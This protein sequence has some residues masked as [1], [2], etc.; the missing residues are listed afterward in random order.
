MLFL[1]VIVHCLSVVFGLL[2][3]VP[4]D[5]GVQVVGSLLCK[6]LLQMFALL[7]GILINWHTASVGFVALLP[8][9]G[10]QSV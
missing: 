2:G 1:R 7:M 9:Y 5:T 4:P 3:D 8:A 6:Q 10:V